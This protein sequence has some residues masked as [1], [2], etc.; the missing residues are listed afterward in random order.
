MAFTYHIAPIGTAY[1]EFVPSV[2]PKITF[3]P[4][5]DEIFLRPVI[6]EIKIS[7]LKN[8]SIYN[9]LAALYYDSSKFNDQIKIIV[10]QN[11]TNKYYFRTSI[12]N[13]TIDSQNSLFKFTPEPDDNYQSIID[14]YERRLYETDLALNIFNNASYYYW[15]HPTN[16]FTN[17]SP[18][19]T[20]FSDSAKV[21]SWQYSGSGTNYAR[22]DYLGCAQSGDQV[23]INITS[24]SGGGTIRLVN[25]ALA[26]VSNSVT[27]TDGLKTMTATAEARYIELAVDT[28][29]TGG[30]TYE[31]YAHQLSEFGNNLKTVIDYLID[32]HY[33]TGIT[34]KSTILFADALPS[35]SPTYISDFLTSHPSRDYVTESHGLLIFND[36]LSIGFAEGFS[37][38]L[39]NNEFTI[40]EVFDI[41]KYKFNIYWYIDS[42]DY[43]RFEHRKYFDLW[44]S[45]LDLT[46]I[47]FAK[48]KPEVDRLLYRYDKSNIYNQIKY[49]ENN[50]TTSDFLDIH[51]DYDVNKTSPKTTSISPPSL[52]TDIETALGESWSTAGFVLVI[53]S[54]INS[55]NVVQLVPSITDSGKYSQN[56]YLSW[57]WVSK[58]Y[59]NWSCDG[60]S[61]TISNGETITAES[62][63]TYLIQD[64]IK[65]YYAGDINWYQS[66]TLLRGLGRIKK[67]E[68]DLATG[69]YTIDVGFDPLTISTEVTADSTVITADSTLITADAT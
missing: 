19:F 57:A 13:T 30:F 16:V 29:T 61:A 22:L 68:H 18:A 66:I 53:T 23:K 6:E 1:T 10:K 41:L 40:K 56:G 42:D 11:G 69:F 59:F 62:L 37:D 17:A 47:T 25:A 46:A 4:F 14:V 27:V 3:A 65:F 24:S 7:K 48:F 21:V 43:L 55:Y 45:Q 44:E 5:S 9:I 58:N 32:S 36:N 50:A 28:G 35:V 20:S 33:G 51:V 60:D 12:S 2:E 34:C 38:E 63:K 49:S 64:G 31:A 15:S 54:V 52:S 39:E 8:E 67:I 26:A